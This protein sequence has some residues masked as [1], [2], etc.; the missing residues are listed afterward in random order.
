MEDF[1]FDYK[2]EEKLTLTQKKILINNLGT[3][4]DCSN[5]FI[6]Q[7]KIYRPKDKNKYELEIMISVK[8]EYFDDDE[9]NAHLTSE[10]KRVI[11]FYINQFKNG[12]ELIW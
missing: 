6:Q 1:G 5:I 3:I 4:A 11:N 12:N 2:L 7:G 9:Y 10:F 8:R